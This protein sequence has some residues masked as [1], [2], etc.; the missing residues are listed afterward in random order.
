MSSEWF[1]KQQQKESLQRKIKS[2]SLRRC[3]ICKRYRS[4]Y[5]LK[6]LPSG[7]EICRKGICRQIF[8]GSRNLD[9]A[10]S[11]Y[12]WNPQGKID[13][14]KKRHQKEKDDFSERLR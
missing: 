9:E 2:G 1:R 3:A 5:G 4:G 6:A 11:T 14:I 8:D 10:I 13:E 12:N 7:K